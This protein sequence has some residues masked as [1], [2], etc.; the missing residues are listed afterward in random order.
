[1][2]TFARSP[3]IGRIEQKAF[4][5]AALMFAPVNLL[6]TTLGTQKP[7]QN[8]D[9]ANPRPPIFSNEFRTFVQFFNLNL[10]GKDQFFA[11]PGEAPRYDYPNP[12]PPRRSID[13]YNFN[14]FNTPIA[15]ITYFLRTA[16]AVQVYRP[17]KLLLDHS[18]PLNITLNTIVIQDDYVSRTP[19]SAFRQPAPSRIVGEQ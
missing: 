2:A 14:Q 9:Y 8:S 17:P 13:L 7:S 4:V 6:A 12:L 18:Q 3:V 16:A 15:S 19:L 11:A 1:M 10:L 5:I